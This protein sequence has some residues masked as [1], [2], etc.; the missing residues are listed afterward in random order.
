MRGPLT[1][2][3]AI[4]GQIFYGQGSPNSTSEK[5]LQ[6]RIMEGELTNDKQ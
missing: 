5:A 4:M 3:M 6:T 1:C 2:R